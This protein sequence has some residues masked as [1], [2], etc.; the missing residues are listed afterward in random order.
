[1]IFSPVRFA[2]GCQYARADSPSPFKRTGKFKKCPTNA[3]FHIVRQ[4][5]LLI[6][7]LLPVRE[8]WPHQPTETLQ[9]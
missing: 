3:M 8:G 1:M 7:I 5:G 9:W 6:N 2:S 4:T